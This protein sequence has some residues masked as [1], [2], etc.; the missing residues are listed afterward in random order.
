MKSF[1]KVFENLCL[2]DGKLKFDEMKSCNGQRVGILYKT[3]YYA[4]FELFTFSC[5]ANDFISPSAQV[6]IAYLRF[7]YCDPHIILL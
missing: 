7:V 2:I 1:S 6:R 5:Y 4:H 3:L